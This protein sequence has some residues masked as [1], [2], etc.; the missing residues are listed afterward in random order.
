MN[1]SRFRAY[2][3]SQKLARLH[4]ETAFDRFNRGDTMPRVMMALLP[5][6]R[7]FMTATNNLASMHFKNKRRKKS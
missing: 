1:A 2:L 4:F 3:Q 6:F 5:A 7:E